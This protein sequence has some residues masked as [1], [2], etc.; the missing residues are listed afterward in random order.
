MKKSRKT[1][2][3][4][5]ALLA[6]TFYAINTPFSK[7]LLSKISPALMAAFLYL[8]AGVGVGIAYLFHI[9][10]EKKSERLTKREL[11]Y[12]IGMILLDI[13]A[14]IFLMI[15][16]KIGSASNASLLSNFEIVATTLIA[17]FVFREMITFRLWIAII[18]ITLSS[19][20]LTFEGT[21]SF[22]LSLGSLFVIMATCCWGLEN[23]CTRKIS[24]KSTYE[25]VFLKGFFSGSASFI[26]AV[27]LGAHIPEFKYVAAAMLLGFVAY[28]LSIFMYIKAQRELGAAKTSAYYAVAPFIGTFLAFVING[29]QLSALY[30]VGLIFMLSGTIFVVYD[31]MTKHHFHGHSHIIVH[32][33]NGTTHTHVITHEHEHNHIASEKKHAHRHNEYMDSEEHKSAHANAKSRSL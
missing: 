19:I 15:G 11:P 20:I 2:A 24:D 32:T 29:E 5:F 21:G 7:V 25:I 16:I 33:H 30:F 1:M 18:L 27:V 14:P 28:G 17:L 10:G 12:A 9:K 22:K 13:A 26:V 31:T 3:V 23:N 4:I 8:G 6:A